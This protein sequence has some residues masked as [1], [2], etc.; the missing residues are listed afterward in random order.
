MS[1]FE[2]LP[3]FGFTKDKNHFL[4]SSAIFK[5]CKTGRHDKLLQEAAQRLVS[6]GHLPDLSLVQAPTETED[7]RLNYIE[8]P[9][10]IAK[11]WNLSNPDQYN[12]F[13]GRWNRGIENQRRKDWE[14]EQ[15]ARRRLNDGMRNNPVGRTIWNSIR[16]YNGQPPVKPDVRRHRSDAGDSEASQVAASPNSENTVTDELS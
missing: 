4:D 1:Q 16:K 6:D 15:R 14:N 13:K 9:L 10:I 7:A 8:S 11:K 3:E 12:D 5:D 2:N